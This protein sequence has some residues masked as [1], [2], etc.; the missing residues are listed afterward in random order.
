[1]TEGLATAAG[2]NVKR[3]RARLNPQD[4]GAHESETLFVSFDWAKQPEDLA[5]AAGSCK[6]EV[7]A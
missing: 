6:A 7:A 5:R 4:V 3:E 1:M 2:S